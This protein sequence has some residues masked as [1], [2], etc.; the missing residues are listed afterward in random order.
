MM[1]KQK[2]KSHVC[3]CVCVWVGGG[4]SFVSSWTCADQSAASPRRG[5]YTWELRS[6]TARSLEQEF[7]VNPKPQALNPEGGCGFGD[8]MAW[9]L[10]V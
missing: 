7:S 1:I 2:Y 6:V 5:P 10:E 3:M 9:G 4:G 8:F